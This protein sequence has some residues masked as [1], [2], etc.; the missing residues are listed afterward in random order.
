MPCSAIPV[1]EKALAFRIKT[2][3]C[4]QLICEIPKMHEIQ[5]M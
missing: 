1:K 3:N 5:G 2:Q 4:N